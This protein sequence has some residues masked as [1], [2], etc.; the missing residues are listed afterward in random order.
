MMSTARVRGVSAQDV[1][2]W[3][4][5]VA[6]AGTVVVGAV[7]AL[8]A[9]T[10]FIV[11]RGL[12]P[13]TQ[14]DVECNPVGE[15]GDKLVVEILLHLKNLG[16]AALI[17]RNTRTDVRYVLHDDP[18]VVFDDSAK[19]TFGRL[20]FEHSL[21]QELEREARSEVN[22]E[23]RGLLV[24]PYSTFVQPGVDQTYTYVTAVDQ[25]AT[26]A[27]VWSSFEYAQNPS[28]LQGSRFAPPGD[29]AS[30]STA[31]RT[32]KSPIPSSEL[33]P[34]STF[35]QPGVDQTYTYVTAVDQRA[36]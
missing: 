3:V 5:I 16:S 34:F 23:R 21:R 35:V 29:W 31:S 10:K 9:Y 2:L 30:F 27:L 25:R 14:F 33:F 24:V 36:T 4:E 17:A 26:Y 19:P 28:R 12:L 13:P 11:E 18:A 7:A 20:R 1:K 32:C 8:W 6:G 15:Q 22:S